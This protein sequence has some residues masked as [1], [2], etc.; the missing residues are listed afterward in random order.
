MI[1]DSY[2]RDDGSLDGSSTTAQ[3]TYANNMNDY[4]NYIIK[5]IGN[6]RVNLL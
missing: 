2:V 4:M 1:L 3:N 5:Q 6:R